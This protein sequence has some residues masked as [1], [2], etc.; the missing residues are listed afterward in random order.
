MN[1]QVVISHP[2]NDM[3]RQ[4]AAGMRTHVGF[5][6]R[7]DD[8]YCVVARADGHEH[9]GL[10]SDALVIPLA[11]DELQQCQFARPGKYWVLK[12]F[13]SAAASGPVPK[14]TRTRASYWV[15]R[16]PVQVIASRIV[17]T[18]ELVEALAGHVDWKEQAA[19]APGRKPRGFSCD[20]E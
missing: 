5:D 7:R 16:D 4:R 8:A 10:P 11:Q 20:S 15:H 9:R 2:Y 17:L 12:G 6:F 13:H 1:P 19:R 18:G 14:P 3:L